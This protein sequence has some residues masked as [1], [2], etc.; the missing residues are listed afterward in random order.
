MPEYRDIF[1]IIPSKDL[2]SPVDRGG[3]INAH[4]YL[5]EGSSYIATALVAEKMK[6]IDADAEVNR[7]P[8]RPFSPEKSKRV[9]LLFPGGIGDVI[10]LNPCLKKF[11]EMYPEKELGI[12][13]SQ[14]DRCLLEPYFDTLWDYPI[15]RTMAEHFDTWINIA[16][17]DRISV[18]KELLDNFADHLHIEKPD[19]AAKIQVDEALKDV[20]SEYVVKDRIS[21]GV[22]VHSA[23]HFRSYPT[24]NAAF[25]MM[26]LAELGCESY[27]IGSPQHRIAFVDDKRRKASPPEHVHDMVGVLTSMEMFIAFVDLM[28]AV[29]TVDTAA[30]HIGGVLG[31]P[32]VGLFGLTDGKVRTSYYPTVEY[33]QGKTDCSPCLSVLEAPPCKG[34]ASWCQALIEMSPT[35]VA[36][37]VMEVYK[38]W[39]K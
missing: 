8:A 37:K 32:T 33:I 11:K 4:I 39:N 2:G 34:N 16:E 25:A 36:F 5:E 3:L 14:S 12:I 1:E 18:Q 29:L 19:E 9:L 17:L 35:D 15:R 31:K 24:F 7:L 13:S 22:Q 38:Q 6:A 23:D 26:T 28:D 20:L 27:I 10:N 30:L 21:V